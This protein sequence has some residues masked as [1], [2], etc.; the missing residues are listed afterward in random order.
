MVIEHLT[1]NAQVATR[2][3]VRSQHPSAQVESD[4]AVLNIVKIANVYEI[5]ACCPNVNMAELRIWIRKTPYSFELNIPNTQ[6]S[7]FI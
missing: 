1:A 6:D 4:E 5:V 2:S 3:W 7:V